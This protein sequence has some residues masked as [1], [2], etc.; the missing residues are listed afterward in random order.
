MNKLFASTVIV[1]GL[2]A[3]SAMATQ[4]SYN[5]L[6]GGYTKANFEGLDPSDKG[7]LIR[8]SVEVSDV[9]Y[10]IG[11]ASTTS[12]DTFV[13][14]FDFREVKLGVGAKTPV[15]DSASVFVEAEYLNHDYKILGDSIDEDGYELS[16]GVKSMVAAQTEV[17]AQVSHINIDSSATELGFGIRQHLN[18]TVG[19]FAE[20]S[21]NDF[22][23]NRFNIGV[24]LQF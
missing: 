4:P 2:S 13:G 9:V 24:N 15:T 23:D 3:G 1:L 16:V 12:F 11:S 6:E 17:F 5:F 21:L 7:F 8:G 19:V 20:Y 18:D 22:D 10:F 14:D